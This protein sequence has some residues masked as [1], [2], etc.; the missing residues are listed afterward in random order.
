[1]CFG[2]EGFRALEVARFSE[3]RVFVFRPKCCC[4]LGGLSGGQK[5]ETGEEENMT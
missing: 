5:K 3:F 4:L 1:M 2:L